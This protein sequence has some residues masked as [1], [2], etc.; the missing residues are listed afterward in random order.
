M[1]LKDRY[2][3]A[4]ETDNSLLV[5]KEDLQNPEFKHAG[6]ST[7]YCEYIGLKQSDLKKLERAGMMIRAYA[8]K[9]TGKS[10]RWLFLDITPKGEV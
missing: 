5:R 8:D 10:T 2:K 6:Y 3:Q 1:T 7:Q 9:G 4:L